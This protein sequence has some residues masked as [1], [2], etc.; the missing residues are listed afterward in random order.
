MT[1]RN[2]QGIPEGYLLGAEAGKAFERK[3]IIEL[4]EA[5]GA[6]DKCFIGNDIYLPSLI[7]LI[8]GETK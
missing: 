2:G 5:E 7:A 3:R 6:L 1:V 4:I 8:N